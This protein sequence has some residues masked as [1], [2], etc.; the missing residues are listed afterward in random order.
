[1]QIE[2]LKH[3]IPPP[4]IVS[5][6]RFL[7]V[8]EFKP[9]LKL[10]HMR[11][12]LRGKWNRLTS[13]EYWPTWV[14]Y[15]P[16]VLSL[17]SRW[18]RK[19]CHPLDFTT[20]N[21]CMPASGLAGESKTDILDQIR[22]RNAVAEYLRIPAGLTPEEKMRRV[23]AFMQERGLSFP[24]VLKPDVGERGR[25]VLIAK[26]PEHLENALCDFHTD[27]LVQAFIPGEEFGVFY[28]LQPAEAQGRIFAITRKTFSTVIGDGV[29][30]LADLILLDPRAVCQAGVHFRQLRERLREIPSEGEGIQLT[31]IGNHARGTL[32]QDG[33]RLITPALEKRIDEISQSLPGFYFGRYDLIAPDVASFQRGEK[34][35]VIE[36]NGV[37]SEATSMYDPT[38]GYRRMVQTLLTQWRI[39]S[40]I[41]RVLQQHG[42]PRTA[43]RALIQTR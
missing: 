20:C 40:E 4:R 10:W 28:I 17:L 31:E 19:G 8:H 12:R 33:T 36:L 18:F 23:S 27:F 14:L 11:R 41:G 35:K 16:V 1:V 26:S 2:K 22:D 13:P 3:S 30:S 6:T 37:S 7:S 21:P 24:L 38:H 42:H 29:H 5:P 9:P 25:Q 15:T 32:F 34:L 43:F 39:A